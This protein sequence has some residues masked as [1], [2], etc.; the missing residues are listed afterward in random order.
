MEKW[1]NFFIVGAPKA[2]TTSLYEYLNQNSDI[3]LPPIKEPN[4]FS[5]SINPKYRFANPIR[6][7]KNYLKLFDDVKNESLIGEAS[8]TYLWDPKAPEL[9]QN[10]S[11]IAKILIMLRDPVERAYSHYLHLSR[12]GR[13]SCTF[14]SIIND[15]NN[16]ENDYNF[17]SRILMA[18]FYAE[19]VKRY[20]KLFGEKQ[21][22]IVIFE[23]FIENTKSKV[24]E[25]LKFLEVKTPLE[26]FEVEKHNPYSE[27][28]VSINKKILNSPLSV[29]IAQNIV[30]RSTRLYSLSSKIYNT[31][32]K[33]NLDNKVVKPKMSKNERLSLKKI[34]LEDVKQLQKIVDV[35]L[36]WPDFRKTE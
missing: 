24:I 12:L 31:I 25:I 9:I 26:K 35:S 16:L 36:P 27:E 2:G 20:L 15:F 19:G 17:S 34:Y 18:S 13:I 33:I 6:N 28:R 4:Y 8:P 7:K 11:P 23:D 32:E 1:P 29:K 21:V 14:S 5:I 10:V 3:Y 22:K 30:S